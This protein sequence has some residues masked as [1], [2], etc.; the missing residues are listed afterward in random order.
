VATIM[1]KTCINRGHQVLQHCIRAK[2]LPSL[3]TAKSNTIIS[4]NQ[5]SVQLQVTLLK[6]YGKDQN[7]LVSELQRKMES[8]SLLQTIVL[9]EII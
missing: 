2:Q 9:Q 4:V 7:S 6:S 3:G 8:Q 5:D 1:D